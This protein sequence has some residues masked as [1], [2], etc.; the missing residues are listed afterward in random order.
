MLTLCRRPWVTSRPCRQRR[1]R[2]GRARSHSPGVDGYRVV[3]SSREVVV[4]SS[5]LRKRWR[6]RAGAPR[7]ARRGEY[8]GQLGA[9]I[10]QLP[11]LRQVDLLGLGFPW[12][13]PWAPW[14]VGWSQR[15]PEVGARFRLG[16]T[17]AAM[18]GLVSWRPGCPAVLVQ[19]SPHGLSGRLRPGMQVQAGGDGHA[20]TDGAGDR[21]AV[22]VEA[23]HPLDRRPLV[24]VGGHRLVDL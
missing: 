20:A 5:S 1:R 18:S 15:R 24:L 22:G 7:R 12:W 6:R 21:A 3:R 19:A 10:E 14:Q 9:A 11:D 8:L 2:P 23:E 4:A 17:R 16:P 13:W